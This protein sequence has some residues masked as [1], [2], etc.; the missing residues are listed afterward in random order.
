[1]R[2]VVLQHPEASGEVAVFL[3]ARVYLRFENS[4]I[5]GPSH[6]RVVDRVAEIQHP[7]FSG[8]N[9]REQIVLA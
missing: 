4:S 9:I 1:M 8:S 5:A 6:Q 3:D 2:P 7:R